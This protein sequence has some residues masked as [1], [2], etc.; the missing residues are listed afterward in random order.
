[1]IDDRCMSEKG[2]VG[3]IGADNNSRSLPRYRMVST[4]LQVL[5]FMPTVVQLC[6]DSN[7]S[8]ILCHINFNIPGSPHVFEVLYF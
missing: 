6:S 4:D 3:L 7:V 2:G 8:Q 5:V 1:M